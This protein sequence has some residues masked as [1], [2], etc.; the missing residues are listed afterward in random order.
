MITMKTVQYADLSRA[1]PGEWFEFKG[2]RYQA[3]GSDSY[4]NSDGQARIVV[5]VRGRCAHCGEL[6]EFTTRRRAS[7]L[8]ITCKKHRGMA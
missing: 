5:T 7:W 2:R 3:L 4:A 6:F 1:L 8:A